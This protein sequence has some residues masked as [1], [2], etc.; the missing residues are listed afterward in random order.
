MRILWLKTELLH[1]VDSGGRI[2]TYQMLRVLKRDHHITYVAL[3]TKEQEEA[4]VDARSRAV[5]YCHEL[6]TV[7]HRLPPKFSKSFY[8]DLLRNLMSPLPFF[9]ERF[10]SPAMRQ[11]VAEL[12]QRQAYDVVVCDFLMPAINMPATLPCATLLFQHNVES[13][14]RRRQ[15]EVE[16]NL[17]K[18]YFLY[19][20]WKKAFRFELSACQRFDQLVAVSEDDSRTMRRDFGVS[21]IITVPTGVDTEY[22]RPQGTS[23][24]WPGSIVFTGS[25]DWLPNE[26]AILYFVK[27][28]YPLVKNAVPKATLTI[29]GRNPYSRLLGLSGEDPSIKV[30]GRVDDVRPFI[31]RASAY[32]VPLRIGGGTRLK[33]FEAMAMEMPVVSTRIGAEGLPVRDQEHLL[34]ADE[35]ETFAAS[36]IKVLQDDEFARS[37][38]KQAAQTVRKNFDWEAV[39]THFVKACEAAQRRHEVGVRDELHV[40][41][42]AP[43]RRQ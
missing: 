33:I 27:E 24:K 30:T 32:I 18:R 39:T 34:L 17:A 21:T 35:P 16:R 5:E 41:R 8:S 42:L 12:A 23:Q 26:D 4:P 40:Q 36:L 15:F 11:K 31:E 10:N 13:V 20:Q 7:P 43:V 38:G 6:V 28:I 29:V 9:V 14:I 22:F 25:M 3:L 2:R 19:L 1:P 37:L